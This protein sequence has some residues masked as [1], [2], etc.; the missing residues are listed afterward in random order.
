MNKTQLKKA[1]KKSPLG[2][3]D[4]VIASK[5]GKTL[6]LFRGANPLAP[7]FSSATQNAFRRIDEIQKNQ[8]SP[9]R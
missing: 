5:D 6:V 1:L 9:M 4:G 7:L 3:F 8:R 2:K